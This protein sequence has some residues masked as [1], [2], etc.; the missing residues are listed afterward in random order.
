MK[1]IESQNITLAKRC[2][3]IGDESR[4]LNVRNERVNVNGVK[5]TK[6]KKSGKRKRCTANRKCSENGEVIGW[7]TVGHRER[8][9]ERVQGKSQRRYVCMY[10]LSR[11]HD[12]SLITD[13]FVCGRT[14]RS[15]S[16]APGLLMLSQ[17][18]M[19][20]IQPRSGE[21]QFS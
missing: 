17:T 12:G 2:R 11:R 19:H 16:Q 20:H 3:R 8:E 21:L 1:S 9:R 13:E 4:R 10:G 15:W 18:I 7:C 14:V 5:A 6:R